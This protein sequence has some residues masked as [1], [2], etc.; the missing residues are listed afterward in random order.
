MLQNV[1]DCV[2]TV[3]PRTVHGEPELLSQLLHLQKMQILWVD[4]V[5]TNSFQSIVLKVDRD[6]LI[7]QSSVVL[8]FNEIDNWLILI[9]T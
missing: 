4:P 6:F 9:D 8:A 3:S 2:R 7:S 1:W 5:L